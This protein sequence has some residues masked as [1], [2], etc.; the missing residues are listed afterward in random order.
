MQQL[1][2][3]KQDETQK[4]FEGMVMPSVIV[5][6]ATAFNQDEE[7]FSFYRTMQAYEESMKEGNTSLVISPD[8]SFFRYFGDPLGPYNSAATSE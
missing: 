2:S 8:S 7:F 3:Q 5:S 1:L 4:K 6:L